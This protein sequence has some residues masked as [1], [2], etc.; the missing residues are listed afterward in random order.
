MRERMLTFFVAGVLT[1]V[2][3]IFFFYQ[4]QPI[5][6]PKPPA[7]SSDTNAPKVPVVTFVNPSHGPASAKVTIVSYE[8]F[9]C[10]V[11]NELNPVL[12][13]VQKAFPNDVKFVWKDM[14]NDSAHPNAT[15]AAIAAH[16]AAQ[17]GKFWEYGQALFQQQASL[18][19]ATYTQIATAL[20]LNTIKFNNCVATKDTLPIIQK[21]A[22]EGTALGIVATPTLFVGTQRF[23]GLDTVDELTAAVQLELTNAQAHAPVQAK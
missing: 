8:D 5:P 21:D 12:E 16:C 13:S 17:Q 18:S 2:V 20:R 10:T 23:V 4:T 9:E 22:E 15:P 11:C 7:S 6:V 1:V 3:F 14:P 19:D